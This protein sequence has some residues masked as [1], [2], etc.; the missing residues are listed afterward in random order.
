MSRRH[1]SF[2]LLII[3][4]SV[5]ILSLHVSAADSEPPV[6]EDGSSLILWNEENAAVLYEKASKELGFP[7]PTAKVM[8]ACVSARI[9]ADRA[10]ETV[11]ITAEMLKG[12]PKSKISAGQSYTIRA[13]IA[14]LLKDRNNDAAYVLA[15]LCCGSTADF[16]DEMNATAVSLGCTGTHFAN[17]TG[18]DASGAST[19]A[20][21]TLLIANEAIKDPI[22]LDIVR[23]AS[24]EIS[25]GTAYLFNSGMTDR[26]GYC[27]I[28]YTEIDGM[29]YMTVLLGG[30]SEAGLKSTSTQLA[31]WGYRNYGTICVLSASRSLCSL[32]VTKVLEKSN[33]SVGITES[34]YAYLPSSVVP[35]TDIVYEIKL[36]VS[37]LEAPV[38][39]GKTVGTVTVSY[40]G[41]VLG[42]YDLVTLEVV[43][44]NSLVSG[45]DTLSAYFQSRSFIAT[46]VTMVILFAAYGCFAYIR[47]R[48]HKAI[49][50]QFDR[51]HRRY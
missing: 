48:R 27:R 46:V 29:H 28:V 26:A 35:E 19:T 30:E 33:V 2:V 13:L 11:E 14:S 36:S 9:L 42:V 16:V 50:R 44:T 20:Y 31:R 18:L 7:G 43:P 4:C 8:T 38:E 3:F 22:I 49:V 25:G 10:D 24:Y 45:V 5:L 17:P 39:I 51:R 23:S 12:A 21:D 41:E 37:S 1:I 40:K 47:Y 6:L 34:V 32:P 15:Y